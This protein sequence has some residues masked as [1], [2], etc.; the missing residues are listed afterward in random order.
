MDYYVYIALPARLSRRVAAIG[1]RYQ[2]STRSE[3]H[4]TLV[5]PRTL[6]SGK[7][8]RDVV[9]EL[10]EAAAH[11]AP[12]RITYRGVGYFG[13]KDFIHVPVHRTRALRSCHDACV[14]AVKGLFETGRP[15]PFSRPHITLAGRFTPEDGNKAWQVL[16]RKIFD[17]QFLCKEILLWRRRTTDPRWRLVSRCRL[18]GES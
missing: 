4:I 1:K 10:R 13:N 11:I 7:S 5:I 2:S 14:R 9:R 17:G 16:K 15:D 18:G 3:P 12:C 6:A 8:E